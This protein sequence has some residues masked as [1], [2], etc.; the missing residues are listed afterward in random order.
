MPSRVSG[1]SLRPRSPAESRSGFAVELGELLQRVV[2]MHVLVARDFLEEPAS[3][4]LIAFFLAWPD[5]MSS[6]RLNVC[7]S[8]ARAS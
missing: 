2:P 5:A 7:L 4:D 6:T 8:R 3:D 1:D